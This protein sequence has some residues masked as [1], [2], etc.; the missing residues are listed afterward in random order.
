MCVRGQRIEENSIVRVLA[1]Y[2]RKPRGAGPAGR[3]SII[4]IAVIYGVFFQALS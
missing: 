4:I 1:V 2:E 3:S